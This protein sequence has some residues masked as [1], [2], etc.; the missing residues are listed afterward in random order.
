MPPARLEIIAGGVHLDFDRLFLVGSAAQAKW[1]E[2]KS[3]GR[4]E[5]QHDQ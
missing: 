5:A 2:T 1:A 4:C 3:M